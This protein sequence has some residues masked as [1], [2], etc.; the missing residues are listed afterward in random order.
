MVLGETLLSSTVAC[1]VV[2][3]VNIETY[4]G[5]RYMDITIWDILG[6]KSARPFW[7]HYLPNAEGL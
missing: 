6:K 2:S 7:K 4:T 1:E 3:K 5:V